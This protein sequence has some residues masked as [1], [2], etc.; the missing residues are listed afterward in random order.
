MKKRFYASKTITDSGRSR[1]WW[2]IDSLHLL[3][4]WRFA[5]PRASIN[6]ANAEHAARMLNQGY[7]A[8]ALAEQMRQV[9]DA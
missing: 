9:R 7:A 4:G 8:L 6:Q 3:P 5:G 1:V 2:C